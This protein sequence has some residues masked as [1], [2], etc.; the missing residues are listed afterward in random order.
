MLEIFG[1]HCD[2][3]R[4]SNSRFLCLNFELQS[5]EKVTFIL[6]DS[7]IPTRHFLMLFSQ[8]EN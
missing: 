5:I 8:E 6:R 7:Q 3:Y 2:Y 4:V 1:Q